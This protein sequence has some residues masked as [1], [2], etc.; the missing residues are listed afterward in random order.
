[1]SISTTNK[2]LSSFSLCISSFTGDLESRAS[3]LRQSINEK[4][5]KLNSGGSSKSVLKNLQTECDAAGAELNRQQ[6]LLVGDPDSC[7]MGEMSDLLGVLSESNLVSFGG[8][9]Q[10][11]SCKDCYFS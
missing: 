9:G 3:I 1:M 5:R 11:S 6:E 7:S 4:G 10:R 8:E 2:D